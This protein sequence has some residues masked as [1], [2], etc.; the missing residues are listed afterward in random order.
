MEGRSVLMNVF[1]MEARLG[2]TLCPGV[3]DPA[4]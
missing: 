3:V 2:R 1:D 4:G